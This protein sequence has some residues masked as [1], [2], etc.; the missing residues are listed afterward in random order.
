[1]KAKR[2]ASLIEVINGNS[3]SSQSE[4]VDA[5]KSLGFDVT[6]ATVSRDLDELGAVKVREGGRVRYA[7][8]D[9]ASGYGASL[10]QVLRQFVIERAMSGN[11]LVLRTPPGHANAVATAV[12]RAQLEGIL[13]T[14]AG[15]DTIFIVCDENYG[16]TRV[17]EVLQKIEH[18]R[19]PSTESP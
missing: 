14:V 4:A 19:K 8:L 17:L 7:V 1:M 5:L 9:T 12:D 6:Q 2:Q 15:D 3:I 13:G 18:A 16:G 11:M 10:S